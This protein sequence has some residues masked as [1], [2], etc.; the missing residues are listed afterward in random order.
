MT[1]EAGRAPS[2]LLFPTAP[3]AVGARPLSRE[4]TLSFL[5]RL[6]ARLR[7][8]APDLI[9]EFFAFGNRRPMSSFPQGGEVYFNAEARTRLAALAQVPPA[10]LEGALPAWAQLEPAGRHDG[11][12]AVTFYSATSIAPTAAACARCTAARTGR[13]EPA[14]LYTAGHQHVCRRHAVWLTDPHD[15]VQG[16]AS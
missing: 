6:A 15:V 16:G 4:T 2:S 5:Q 12:P 14:S 7:T 1:M 3:C 13:A 10:H 11:G 8:T 9:A